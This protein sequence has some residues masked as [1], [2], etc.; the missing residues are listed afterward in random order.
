MNDQRIRLP[1]MAWYGDTD[2]EL[3]FPASWEGRASI[4]LNTVPA[5]Y[6]LLITLHL[7]QQEQVS[8]SKPSAPGKARWSPTDG[9]MRVCV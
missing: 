6:L 3:N 2:I 1:Q 4:L 5:K 9:F 7:K 8:I